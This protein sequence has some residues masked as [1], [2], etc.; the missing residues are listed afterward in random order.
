LEGPIRERTASLESANRA[1]EAEIAAHR[2]VAE[3][4]RKSEEGFRTLAESLPH[5]VWT[6]QPDGRCDYLSRQ[7]THYAG[8]STLE[9][10]GSS[11]W[12]QYLH[13]D[14]RER[15]QSAWM[16]A[17]QCGDAFEAESRIRRADGQYRW[18]KLRA[19]PLRDGSGR[20]VKWFGSHTDIEDSRQAHL[21]A[22]TQ[23]ERLRLLDLITRAIG[24]HQDLQ[25]IFRVVIRTLEDRLPIDFG[26]VCLCESPQQSMTVQ[27]VGA[28]PL[29]AELAIAEGEKINVEPN[30]L[31]LFAQGQL[32]YEPELARVE[33]PFAQQL[34]RGG[35]GSMVMSPLLA[36]GKVFSILITA[37]RVRQGFS[38]EDCEFIRQL[39]EHVALAAGQAQMYTAL[40][41]AYEELRQTT[42]TVLLQER[43]RALGQMASGIAHDINNTISPISLYTD[44]LLEH[45]PDL[46]PRA[47]QYL[48]TIGDAVEAVVQTVARLRDFY[49]PRETALLQTRVDLNEL[50]RQVIDLTRARWSDLPQQRGLVI[51]VR[52]ELWSDLPLIRGADDEIR[53]AL[54]N[55]IFNA[56][57]AMPEGGTLTLR[58]TVADL[59][60][61]PDAQVSRYVCIE[62]CD[63]GVGMD[64]E[65]RRRCIEPFFTTKGEQG[66]G[67]GLAGVYGMARRHD[68]ILQIDSRRGTGTTV[69]L[70][71]PEVPSAPVSGDL[72]SRSRKPRSLRVLIVDDDPA[73]LESLR[74]ALHSEGHFVTAVE[75]GQAGIDT[76]VAAMGRGEPFSVVITDLGMPYVDGRKVATA[77]RAAAPATPVILLTGW[78]RRMISEQEVPFGVDRVLAKPPRLHELQTVL[79]ELTEGLAAPPPNI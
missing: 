9:A 60:Q 58:T 19:V 12:M 24:E 1:L 15:V 33:W 14:D 62:V 28:A 56:V 11:G 43:L 34:A 48:K 67:L 51:D 73:I 63:T 46:S 36:D 18:F 59:D 22:A 69:R 53:D 76:F 55:L 72:Q 64:E 75:G 30:S 31:L 39:S 2:E 10:L 37:R 66:T 77:V 35:L 17:T 27:Y 29:A 38:S 61:D 65:T 79:A 23:L 20:I 52:K 44:I 26:C 47:R 45:E 74:N 78:G 21:R 71:F 50:I 70:M 6:S 16:K 42:R 25:S 68:A 3:A 54:T 40:Q 8:C 57:D 5:L 41:Q 13:A 49:R 32:V 4:L 7:W